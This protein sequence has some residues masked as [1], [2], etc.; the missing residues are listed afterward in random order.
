MMT[1]IK[2]ALA[3]AKGTLLQDAAGLMSLVAM[4]VIGLNLPDLI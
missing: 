1:E 3:H 2:S 4:L